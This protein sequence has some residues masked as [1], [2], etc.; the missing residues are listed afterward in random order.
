MAEEPAE[1]GG[2]KMYSIKRSASG[3][4]VTKLSTSQGAWL[5]RKGEEGVTILLE[6][7]ERSSIEATGHYEVKVSRRKNPVSAIPRRKPEAPQEEAT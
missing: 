3:P 5:M 7:F 4:M 1:E 2:P 6:D